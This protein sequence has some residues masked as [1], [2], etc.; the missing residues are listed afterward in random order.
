MS[1]GA[2]GVVTV[3]ERA[4]SQRL[5]QQA[6]KLSTVLVSQEARLLPFLS[7]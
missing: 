1:G 5:L 6:A 2:V 7:Q 3:Q 4:G